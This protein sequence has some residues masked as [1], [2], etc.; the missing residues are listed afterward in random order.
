LKKGGTM[1]AGHNLPFEFLFDVAEMEKGN[2]I[3]RHKI[4]Y[5][6]IDNEENL[7]L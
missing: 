6:D 3:V 5:S 7:Y 1:L 2:L 4:P